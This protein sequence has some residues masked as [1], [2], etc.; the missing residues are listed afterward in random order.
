MLS[1]THIS[2][3]SILK[4]PK[5][6]ENGAAAHPNQIQNPEA[7]VH[8]DKKVKSE[9]EAA[10]R[11]RKSLSRNWMNTVDLWSVQWIKSMADNTNDERTLKHLKLF[12]HQT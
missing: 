5:K 7:A 12:I 9:S 2:P 3:Q 8:L 1:K 11:S 6:S 10:E 4:R